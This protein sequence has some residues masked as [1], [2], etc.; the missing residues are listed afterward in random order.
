ML[1]QEEEIEWLWRCCH[2][3]CDIE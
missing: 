3:E 1:L 2:L